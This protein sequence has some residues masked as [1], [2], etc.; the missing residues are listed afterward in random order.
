MLLW[1]RSF[2]RLVKRQRAAALQK[3]R[4]YEALS[5]RAPASWTAAVL[6]RFWRRPSSFAYLRNPM[7]PFFVNPHLLRIALLILVWPLTFSIPAPAQSRAAAPFSKP[8]SGPS[9]KIIL[10]AGHP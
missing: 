5:N 9:R 4:Q 2:V 1:L 7:N 6:C 10:I 8:P 3:L